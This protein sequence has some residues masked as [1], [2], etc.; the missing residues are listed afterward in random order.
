MKRKPESSRI[1]IEPE[2][3]EL[4]ETPPYRFELTRRGFLGSLGAGFVV[5][6]SLDSR[7]AL[8]GPD[9][10]G[11]AIAARLHIGDDGIVTVF[12]SKVEVG[13]GS[14]TQLTQAA[15]EELRLPLDRVQLVLADTSRVPDD[16]GTYGSRTT[17]YTV[18][19]VRQAA[20]AA[21]QVLVELARKH[22]AVESTHRIE[23]RDGKVVDLDTGSSC[24]FA[25][26]SETPAAEEAF[27]AS[28]PADIALTPVQDWTVLGKAALK[29]TS[30]AVATGALKY[31]SDIVRPGMLRGSVL[32]P[33]SYSARLAS[34][35]ESAAAAIRGAVVVRDG[36][37][38]ACA[39]KTSFDARRAVAALAPT[40][41]WV[42]SDPISGPSMPS[43]PSSTELFRYLKDNVDDSQELRTSWSRV[44]G[45]V[46]EAL[47]GASKKLDASFEV[48]YIQHAPMEPRAACAEWSSAGDAL[49]LTV[50]TG[51]QRPNGVRE[52]LEKVFE[53]AEGKV[54]VIVPDTG[55]GFGGKH[56]GEVAVEAARLARAAGRPVSVRWTREEE[57]TWAYFRPSALIEARGGIDEK[58]AL[59]AWDFTCYNAGT[60]GLET[61]YEA[62]PI[63]ER[64]LPVRAPLRQ[65]SYRGLAA[66]ANHFARESFMDELAHAASADPLSF[67][68]A[69]LKDERLRDVLQK[70]AEAFRY[71]ERLDH[72]RSGNGQR[73]LG[74]ACGTEKGSYVAACVAVKIDRVRGR[75]AVEEIVETYECGAIQNPVNLRAQVQGAIVMGLGGALKEEIRFENGRVTNPRFSMYQVPRTRDLVPMNII[76]MDR[77]DLPSVGAGETPIIAVAPAIGNAVFHATGLRIRSMPIR[78]DSPRLV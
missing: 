61:P 34:V 14:R 64:Y 58:G 70:A 4:R 56:T 9:E 60:S 77:P 57:F 35:D 74:L 44:E 6:A 26:L 38:V 42:E 17:G 16:G 55:G 53:L 31:P 20:A 22:W 72:V 19:P 13:Q 32:R 2:R 48:A 43:M 63:R 54:T 7:L 46:E 1:E 78:W 11:P 47:A 66:T 36:D 25:E 71:R 30:R 49:A 50:W 33:P 3:F 39:A 51:T 10:A 41:R 24:T 23:L 40:A 69:H 8:A 59:A 5:A 12:S 15:A 75:I 37:F 21:R 62:G 27:R 18:P 65:G 45:S 67:R 76:L 68:L 29:P 52:E 73:G 28:V